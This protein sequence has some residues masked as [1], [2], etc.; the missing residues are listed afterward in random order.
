[1]RGA[2]LAA[3][4]GCFQLASLGSEYL[5][6]RLMSRR[7]DDFFDWLSAGMCAV[8]LRKLFTLSLKLAANG[9]G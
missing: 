9:R 1:M 3:A 7:F 8:A 5:A 6:Q 2:K 4:G